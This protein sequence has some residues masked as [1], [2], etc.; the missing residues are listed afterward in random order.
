[1]TPFVAGIYL[2]RRLLSSSSE[3]VETYTYIHNETSSYKP[4]LLIFTTRHSLLFP[5]EYIKV[6]Q[7]HHLSFRQAVSERRINFLCVC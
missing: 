3:D 1:M 4:S 5:I 2:R 6:K 7:N